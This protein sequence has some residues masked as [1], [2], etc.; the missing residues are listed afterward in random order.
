MHAI[1][2]GTRRMTQFGAFSE[3]LMLP[4]EPP[5]PLPLEEPCLLLG[6]TG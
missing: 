6:M 3:F 4:I 1:R 5:S 2:W